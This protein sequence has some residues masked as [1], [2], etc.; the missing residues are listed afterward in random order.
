[1]TFDLRQSIA[2]GLAEVGE[3][4]AVSTVLVKLIIPLKTFAM[5]KVFFFFSLPKSPAL[6]LWLINNWA[7]WAA[8]LWTTKLCI[9]SIDENLPLWQM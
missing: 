7:K 3:A 2:G 4:A 1:M 8:A 5:R 9:A 6:T